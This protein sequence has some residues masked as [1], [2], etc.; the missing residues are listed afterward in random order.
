MAAR[1]RLGVASAGIVALTPARLLSAPHGMGG[2]G[3][4]VGLHL[5]KYGRAN[6]P[7][8]Q[9]VGEAL[10]ASRASLVLG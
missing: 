10:S 1:C 6:E 4:I 7:Y 8:S 5:D 9:L 3:L 2:A